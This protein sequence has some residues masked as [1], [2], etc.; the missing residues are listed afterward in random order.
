LGKLL[1]LPEEVTCKEN[2]IEFWLARSLQVLLG[3]EEWRNSRQGYR[4]RTDN[5]ITG[6]LSGVRASC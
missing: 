1:K 5:L 4:A 2:N 3:Y 6:S